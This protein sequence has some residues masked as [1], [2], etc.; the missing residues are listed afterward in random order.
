MPRVST[1]Q[2]PDRHGVDVDPSQWPTGRLLSAA[3]RRMEHGWNSYLARWHLNHASLP[4]LAILM[5]G[6]LSQRDLAAALGVTEQTTSRI[7][8]GLERHGYVTRQPHPDD[9]RV[10]LLAA[11]P[12]GMRV[13]QEL[14]Q[15][16]SIDS[17]V[18]HE[19]SPDDEARLRELLLR[20]L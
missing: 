3:A 11:S 4:A 2:P 19:L 17:I 15:A 9:R 10:R 13:M 8:A 5:A 1:A 14:D 6:P 16:G 12:T 18:R 7:V 20:F